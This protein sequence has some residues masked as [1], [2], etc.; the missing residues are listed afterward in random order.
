[1]SVATISSDPIFQVRW[2]GV[3]ARLFG[4]VAKEDV[5]ILLITQAS[6]EQAICFVTPAGASDAIIAGV[7]SEFAD[8]IKHRDIDRVRVQRPVAIVTVV[9]SGMRGVPG[10][11]GRVFTALSNVNVL[12]IAQGSSECSIS[13]VV[14][15][16]D[17]M[18]AVKLLHEL[19][20]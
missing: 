12:A 6:S 1:M 13:A 14:A 18:K 5:S 8:E 17:A 7:E 15:E 9:G 11:S 20:V 10:V 3:A 2:P 19:I 16:D 4:A